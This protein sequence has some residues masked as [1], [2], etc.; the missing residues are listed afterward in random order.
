MAVHMETFE[1]RTKGKGTYEVTDEVEKIVARSK[2]ATG[3][4]GRRGQS[5]IL[6][7]FESTPIRTAE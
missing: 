3:T 1:A 2:I 4:R 7:V 5:V 6:A